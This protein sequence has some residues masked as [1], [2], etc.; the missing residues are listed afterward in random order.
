MAAVYGQLND[1]TFRIQDNEYEFGIV[2]NAYTPGFYEYSRFETFWPV[3]SL[4]AGHRENPDLAGY[5][6]LFRVYAENEMFFAEL[7][8]RADRPGVVFSGKEPAALI[9]KIQEYLRSRYNMRGPLPPDIRIYRLNVRSE[10]IVIKRHFR[11]SIQESW[12]LIRPVDEEKLQEMHNRSINFIDLEKCFRF[13][14]EFRDN[15]FIVDSLNVNPDNIHD[16][17]VSE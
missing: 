17:I 1:W 5:S 15:N 7:E 12:C 8:V 13:M 2:W 4:L 9:E 3:I 10:N 11:D 16:F 14:E 6:D